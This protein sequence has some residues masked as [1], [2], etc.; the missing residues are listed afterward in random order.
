M[1][2]VREINERHQAVL[3]IDEGYVPQTVGRFAGNV[4][5][6]ELVAIQAQHSHLGEVHH[7]DRT[8]ETAQRKL[9][10]NARMQ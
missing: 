7:V 4:L 6:A 9:C 8:A 5:G 1:N 3:H 2:E 10:K